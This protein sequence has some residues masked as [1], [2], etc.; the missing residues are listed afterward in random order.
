MII[1]VEQSIYDYIL[2]NFGEDFV[3]IKDGDYCVYYMDLIDAGY[4]FEDEAGGIWLISLK[5]SQKGVFIGN[6]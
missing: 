4:A 3:T 1:V 2:Q 6:L 5:P